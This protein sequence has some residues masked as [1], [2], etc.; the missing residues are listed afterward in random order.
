LFGEYVLQTLAS[1][2]NSLTLFAY[3]EFFLLNFIPSFFLILDFF[4][5]EK[6]HRESGENP[7]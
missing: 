7:F 6:A 4:N 5:H 1:G 2:F 3:A